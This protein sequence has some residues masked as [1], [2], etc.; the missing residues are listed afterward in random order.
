MPLFYCKNKIVLPFF[1][2]KKAVFLPF[3]QG[4]YARTELRWKIGLRQLSLLYVFQQP[5]PYWDNFYF[6]IIIGL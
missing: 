4:E 2:G 1:Q 3:F 6:Y 5:L